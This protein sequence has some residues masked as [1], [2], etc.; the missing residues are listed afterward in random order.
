MMKFRA[1]AVAGVAAAAVMAAMPAAS[2]AARPHASPAVD[3]NIYCFIDNSTS[4]APTYIGSNISGSQVPMNSICRVGFSRINYENPSGTG[5]YEYEVTYGPNQG[6]CLKEDPGITGHPVV[7]YP[8][9]TANNVTRAEEEWSDPA[10]PRDLYDLDYLHASAGKL[11]TTV[12]PGGDF[13]LPP[14]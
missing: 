13:G 5:Y 9:T 6:L 4:P 2:A 1:L 12:P 14:R 10:T 8:C 3:N 7:D 11:W